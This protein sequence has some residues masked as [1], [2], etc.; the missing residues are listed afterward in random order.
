[1]SKR[2]RY[3]VVVPT[4]GR[5]SL[6]VLLDAVDKA[7]GPAPQ[8]VVVVDD[9]PE[10]TSPLTLPPMALP[11]HVL[12]SGG[13]GP[14]AARNVGWRSTA[15]E[16]IAFLDDDVVPGSD[17][18]TR[19]A[20]DLVPLAAD[21]AASQG[22]IVVPLPE[23]RQ[24][25]DWERG[26][27]GL[28]DARWITADMAYR[29]SV[30]AQLGGF[31]ERFRRAY[32]EDADLALRALESGYRIEYGRRTTLHPVRPAGFFAS[33]RAQA[34]N[35][36]DAL[37][38]RR[39]GRLWR[40]R[41]AAGRGR[42]R[43]HIATAAA[44]VAA[45]GFTWWRRTRPLGGLAIAAWAVLTTEFAL[46]RILPGPRSRREI[47][48]MA[49]TSVAIPLLACFHRLRGEL[50]WRRVPRFEPTR[51]PGALLFD[52]DDTLIHDV[53]YNGDPA[54]VRPVDGAREVLQR[55]R[56]LKVPIGVI[57][58]QSGI[59]RGLF[60]AEQLTAV[61]ARVEQL[62]GPFDT[63]QLCPHDDGDGCRCRK[64]R[65][66]LVRQAAAA[67]GVSVRS[68]VVI[69]DTGADVQAANAAGATG[70]LVPTARTLPDE[71]T[72]ARHVV[73]DL[74]AAVE[75]ALRVGTR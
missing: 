29:R 4:T 37:M 53:P 63:W 20:A 21:V 68:C 52:R 39:H 5:P 73:G 55:L 74:A 65:S 30:L 22:R 1:M 15:A 43:Q 18:R 67:L 8:E 50:Q 61:N 13:H 19:L 34:G 32:R 38:R 72:A 47:T 35:A 56:E 11:V 57:S 75:L 44:A 26:T 71:V 24:P 27:A 41:S 14:A 48:R 40:Q 54:K 60:S 33:V 64:P 69:G 49:L 3:S 31:D 62:L 42:L 7:A 23:D 59:A 45:V 17:W 70:I 28:Q 2:I 9:R 25:T 16:W 10:I 58:N 66:G 6:K 36:D 12:R 46:R 51:L